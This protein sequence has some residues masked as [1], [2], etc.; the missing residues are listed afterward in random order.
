MHERFSATWPPQDQQGRTWSRLYISNFLVMVGFKFRIEDSKAATWNKT[1]KMTSQDTHLKM[2][3][4]LRRTTSCS[5]SLQLSASCDL[6]LTF[7]THD[8]HQRSS[9]TD[10][11]KENFPSFI[12]FLHWNFN[13]RAW[14]QTGERQ[15]GEPRTE[16]TFLLF[17]LI[18]SVE[19]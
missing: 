13:T 6:K 12:R 7:S 17:L 10:S 15:T 5:K 2:G 8:S 18:K 16:L 1:A 3:K 19:R 9:E 11:L 4:S 14:S